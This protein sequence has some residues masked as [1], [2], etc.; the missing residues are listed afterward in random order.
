MGKS[1]EE[2]PIP[3]SLTEILTRDRGSSSP[4]IDSSNSDEAV[5]MISPLVVNLTAL[6]RCDSV[7]SSVLVEGENLTW[8]VDSPQF[9]GAD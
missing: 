2:I 4:G 5:T 6:G 8:R 3:V 1:F 7:S 9:A